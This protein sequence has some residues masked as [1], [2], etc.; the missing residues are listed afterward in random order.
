MSK[1]N[2]G[3]NSNGFGNEDILGVIVEMEHN[4]Q[5][6]LESGNYKGVQTR[7]RHIV[8]GTV[9]IIESHRFL[10]EQ[11]I[12][13]SFYWEQYLWFMKQT[14]KVTNYNSTTIGIC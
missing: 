3:I 8:F 14:C 6:G 9:R 7:D 12:L 11:C 13:G 1:K 2:Q 10:E 5:D 4:M